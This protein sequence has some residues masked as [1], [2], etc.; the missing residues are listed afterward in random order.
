MLRTSVTEQM[1]GDLARALTGGPGGGRTLERLSTENSFV[2]ALGNDHAGYRYHPLLRDVLAAERARE[3]PHEVPILLRRAARWPAAHDQAIDALRSAAEAG[4]WAYA[5]HM[6][7][8]AGIAALVR[9]GAATLEQ[10]LALFPAEQRAD[11]AA[12]AAALAAA[13]LWSGDP[14]GAGHHLEAAQR[15][16]G[17]CSQGERRSVEPWLAALRALRGAIGGCSRGA[18]RGAGPWRGALRVMGA[19]S[20]SAADPGLLAQGWS[21][22]E[23]AQAT[24]GTQPEHRALGLLWFALGAA[25]LRRWE[26]L[27]ARYALN[28]AA[29]QL[30]AGG[31]GELCARAR[32]WQALAEA[33]HGDLTAAEKALGEPANAGTAPDPGSA[34]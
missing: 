9:S 17:R 24:A 14:D 11:D 5:A 2:E 12:V 28:H 8:E 20:R 13:R 15:A 18:R 29:R 21:M 23:Q 33:W 16:I 10:V 3:I 22:A 31:L 26:I 27:E 7:A 25:R 4:D 1:S 34:G 19:A 30:T 6:L 32:G